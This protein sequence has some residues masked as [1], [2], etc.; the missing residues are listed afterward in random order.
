MGTAFVDAGVTDMFS[1]TLLNG[2]DTRAPEDSPP[3]RRPGALFSVGTTD[4]LF[5]DSLFMDM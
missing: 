2:V 1:K 5:E 4:P 3:E